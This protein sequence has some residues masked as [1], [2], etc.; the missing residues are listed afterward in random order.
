[1]AERDLSTNPVRE[2]VRRF[3]ITFLLGVVIYRLGVFVPIP[4]VEYLALKKQ[5]GNPGDT[6]ALT[7]ILRY[8]DMFNGGTISNA[9]IFGL[10]IMPF[11]FVS[12]ILQL[13]TLDR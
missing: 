6:S 1:M 11:I 9:S 12:I 2:L 3:L 8:A 10:G 5:I 7:E 4:G 13:L